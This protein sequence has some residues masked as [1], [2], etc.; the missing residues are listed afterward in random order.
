[1]VA[2]VHREDLIRV[3]IPALRMKPKLIIF[4]FWG[5]LAYSPRKDWKEF[6][7]S[8]QDFGIDIKTEKEIKYFSSLFSKLMCLS[9]DWIDFSQQ[10]LQEFSK[11]QGEKNITEL[12]NFLRENIAYKIYDDVK[13]ALDLPYAKAILTDSARF[14]VENSE[15]KDLGRIFTPAETKALKPDS[16]V[17]LTVINEFKIKAE[18]A[19]MVGDDIERDLIPAKN[20]G[21]KTVLIDRENKF[22]D[23]QGSRINSF[24]ELKKLLEND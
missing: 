13:E 24:K 20:L 21:M 2:R 7:S 16:R 5:T 14:L 15:L 6:Y 17:F 19:V 3:Q 9:K 22:Q 18:E 4:D 10:L 11:K 12:A 8:L 1:M 23:Y